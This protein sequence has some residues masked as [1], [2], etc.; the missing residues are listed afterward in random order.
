[1]CERVV[2]PVPDRFAVLGD[3]L[4]QLV[5]VVQ[6]EAEVVVGLGE[7]WPQPDRLAECVDGL[8]QLP[9]FAEGD[10]EVA[11]SR[12]VVGPSDE[13]CAERRDAGIESDSGLR[14]AAP[15]PER[16]AQADEMMS[17]NGP[18]SDQVLEHRD[19]LLR[20]SL[21]LQ[22]VPQHV[23]GLGPYRPRGNVIA[24]RLLAPL[25]PLQAQGQVVVEPEVARMAALGLAQH[26]LRRSGITGV[27]EGHPQQVEANRG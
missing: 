9:L 5:L 18:E 2:G 13:V 25:Q 10:A 22:G 26:A 24:D 16:P 21:C 11:V 17:V 12:N 3:R 27:S 20:L 8:G 4:G 7:L 6:G 19:P 23:G 1:M 14:V 15:L